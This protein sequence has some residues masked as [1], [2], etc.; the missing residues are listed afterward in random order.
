MRVG[1]I[2]VGRIGRHHA[3]IVAAHPDV[4]TVVITDVD[5]GR[6]SEIATEVHGEVAADA[7]SLLDRVDDADP[8]ASQ[9]AAA[10]N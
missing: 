2:G 1:I 9:P 6:A 8:R 4:D 3:A 10:A 5:A 7:A